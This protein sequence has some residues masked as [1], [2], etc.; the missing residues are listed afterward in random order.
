MDQ[1]I[2][3]DPTRDHRP[4]VRP[5]KGSGP[6]RVP[7]FVGGFN[8]IVMRL[9]RIGIPVGANAL[10]TVRG[11]RSGEPRTTPVTVISLNGRRWVQSP[12]GE[13]NWVRNLRAVGEATLTLGRREEAIRAVELSHDEAV[14]FFGEVLAPEIR[15]RPG[16]RLMARMLGLR[17]VLDDPAGA[18]DRHP[19]FQ[20]TPALRA[21]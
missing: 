9:A 12:F 6:A 16:G 15:R 17:D 3:V 5:V 1:E 13:V 21:G 4:A 8:R 2:D 10:L 18:A 19:V 11:R 14:A 20:L 7:A